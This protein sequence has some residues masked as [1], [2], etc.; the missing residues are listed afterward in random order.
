MVTEPARLD[1]TEAMEPPQRIDPESAQPSEAGEWL[2]DNQ[3]LPLM[4]RPW[5]LDRLEQIEGAVWVWPVIQAACD[6]PDPAGF[7]WFECDIDPDDLAMLERYVG[8]ADRLITSTVMNSDATVRISLMSGAVEKS[9][10]ADDATVGFGALLRQMFKGSEEASFDRVRNTLSK[11]AKIAGADDANLV[12][13]KWK[14][15]HQALLKKHL[16]AL[17]H[18]IAASAGLASADDGDGRRQTGT[19]EDLSPEKLIEV[20]LHGDMLH[21]GVGRELLKQWSAT[22]R[23]AAEMEHHMRNDAHVLAHFYAEF[24]EIVQGVMRQAGA[25]P[26]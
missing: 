19:A 10:P 4:W 16:R 25:A 8:T 23:E 22:E 15:A 7:P 2:K 20:F 26:S 21:W 9:V 6:L 1:H 13:A 18:E 12:L 14:K 17:M 24:S 3:V 11:M 5:Y